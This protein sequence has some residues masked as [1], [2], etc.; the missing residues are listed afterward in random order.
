MKLLIFLMLVMASMT[1]QAQ[2]FSPLAKPSHAVKIGAAAAPLVQNNFRPVASVTAIISDT[3]QLAGGFGVGFQH[4]KWNDPAQTWDTQYSL[5]ALGF[6]GSSGG[7]ATFTGG[8]VFGFLNFISIGYGYDFTTKK[9][10]F[11]TGVQLH[12]N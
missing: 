9:S 6:L 7:K 5:S 8:I 3:T 2:F 12:F 10:G 4:N 11:L 1:T